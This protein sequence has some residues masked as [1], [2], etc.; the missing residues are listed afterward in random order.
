MREREYVET[1][2][3]SRYIEGEESRVAGQGDVSWPLPRCTI[4]L[5]NPLA[6]TC[7]YILIRQ[8]NV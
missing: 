4:N 5:E 1:K 6:T 3:E 2:N 8:V 7:R